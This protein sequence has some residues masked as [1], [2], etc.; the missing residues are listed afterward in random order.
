[1]K[2]KVSKLMI[3]ELR[4]RLKDMERKLEWEQEKQEMV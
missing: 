2:N 4:K 1:M 3:V